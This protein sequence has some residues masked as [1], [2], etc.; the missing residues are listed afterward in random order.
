MGEN[1]KSHS[2]ANFHSTDDSGTAQS[3]GTQSASSIVPLILLLFRSMDVGKEALVKK[4]AG[5]G[6]LELQELARSYD[7]L[8]DVAQEALREEF[9]RRNLQPEWIGDAE[10]SRANE[11][12]TVRRYRDLTE[13]IVARSVLESA[14][15]PAYL[16]DENLVRMDWLR[17]NFIGGMRLQVDADNGQAAAH[18]L[19]QP[20]TESIIFDEELEFSQ[21]HCPRCNSTDI[22]MPGTSHGAPLGALRVDSLPLPLD[23]DVWLCVD[24]GAQWEELDE[25]SDGSQDLPHS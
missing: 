6:D 12:V 11:F 24:C 4:Y 5:L 18:L 2:T 14:G 15:I 13:A 22:T 3:V 16:R 20:I 7:S 9:A 17:S 1:I 8:A 21:P 25:N 19:A 10:L 23:H